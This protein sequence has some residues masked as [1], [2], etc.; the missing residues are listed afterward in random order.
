EDLKQASVQVT[1]LASAAAQPARLEMRGVLGTAGRLNVRG[2]VRA[3]G[4]PMFVDATAELRD[5]AIPRV[6]PYL[7]HFTAWTAR[8]GRR[9]TKLAGRVEGDPVQA[10]TQTLIGG[11]QVTRVASDDPTEKRM[12]L[13]LGMVVALLADRE[14]NIKLSLPVSGRLSDPHFDLHDA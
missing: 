6:N 5:M 14:G 7:R 1:G 3:L 11:L 10:R 2:Q 12:G 4:E 13:P 9:E 8:K